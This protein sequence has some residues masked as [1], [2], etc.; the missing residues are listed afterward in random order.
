MT[1][2][3]I[4]RLASSALSLGA[5]VALSTG[6]GSGSAQQHPPPPSVTVASAEGKEIVEWDEFTGRVEAVESDARQ[7]RYQ[8]AKGALQAAQAALDSAR[9]DLEYTQV[10][11][12]IDGRVSRAL[13]TEGNYVSGIAGAASLLTTLVSVNPIYAY[14]DIDENSLLKFNALAQAKK[15][16]TDGDGRIPVELQLADEQ[17]FPHRGYLESFDNR[18]DPNTGSILLRAVFPNGDGRIL[19]GLFARI[20]VPADFGRIRGTKP[21]E[22]ARLQAEV[23]QEFEHWLASGYAATGIDRNDEAAEYLL[24]PWAEK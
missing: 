1:S 18:L 21:E 23:R 22:A 24:E 5:L 9:L 6:C 10:R 2:K 13:L 4:F 14:A 8:E 3:I 20:R 11:A 15:L 19:P 17:D 12:P 7:A 16:E